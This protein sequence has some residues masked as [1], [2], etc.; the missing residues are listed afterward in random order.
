MKL[1]VTG[2]SGLLGKQLKCLLSSLPQVTSIFVVRRQP[3][4]DNELYWNFK[5]PLPEDISFDA[6]LHMASAIDYSPQNFII[7]QNV[8][9]A[10]F[11][12]EA[13]KRNNANVYFT[14]TASIHGQ[15]FPWA[16]DSP[17]EP[18]DDYAFSK[19]IC[20]QIFQTLPEK[21]CIFRLNGIYGFQNSSHLGINKAI[22]QALVSKKRPQLFGSGTQLRNYI[23]DIS[24]A[25]WI[26]HEVLQQE[27]KSKIVYMAGAEVLPIKL[28]LKTIAEILLGD[29]T[30]DV[31][32][33]R[34]NSDVLVRAS[35][36][37]IQMP[38]FSA[39]L[40]ALRTQYENMLFF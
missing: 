1:L 36:C 30:L 3:V 25:K 33:G 13:A 11:L 26:L 32:P 31:H 6:L 7:R 2:T 14:S 34:D 15:H 29:E 20:E 16:I 35:H 38:S 39:Y 24:A 10:I 17:I 21:V 5:E 19:L 40:K 8:L 4:A 22:Y 28:W 18:A 12:L 23:S 37:P 27:R 9:P